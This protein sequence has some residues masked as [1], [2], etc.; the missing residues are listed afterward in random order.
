[1]HSADSWYEVFEP[2]IT[3]SGM[4]SGA[5]EQYTYDMDAEE[6][7][8]NCGRLLERSYD[9]NEFLAGQSFNQF[10]PGRYRPT[11]FAMPHA[12]A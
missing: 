1:M 9:R 4:M 7:G 3:I 8:F 2:A 5:A 12:R 11:I 10:V 6:E